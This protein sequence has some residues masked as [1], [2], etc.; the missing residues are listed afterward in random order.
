MKRLLLIFN[1][2]FLITYFSFAKNFKLSPD[3]GI[4]VDSAT[5]RNVRLVNDTMFLYYGQD[6]DTNGTAFGLAIATDAPN[7]VNF[8]K[9]N[10]NDY[11]AYNWHILPDGT[12]RKYFYDNAQSGVVS[13]SSTNGIISSLD[14]GVRYG[15]HSSDNNT[16]GVSTYFNDSLD[17]VH[18]LYIGDMGGMDNVRHAISTD[19]GW[20]F[21]YLT[22]NTFGDILGP[23]GNESYWDPHA[24]VMPDHSV[25]VFVINQHGI[26]AP[27]FNPTGLLYS[28]LSTDNGQTFS[29]ET[30]VNGDSIRLKFDDFTSFTNTSLNDPKGVLLPD[31]R[32]KVYVNGLVQ[33]P[34]N[35]YTW[36]IISA[37][38]DGPLSVEKPLNSNFQ[39]NVFPNPSQGEVSINLGQEFEQIETFIFDLSGQMVSSQNF[40]HTQNFNLDLN[41]NAGVYFLK[42]VSNNQSETVK[43]IVN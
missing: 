4:R 38:S 25:R 21:S 7:Y 41:L 2:G 5:T 3:I 37:T 16:Y 30:D 10:I 34:D 26:G 31:G 28:F 33:Q 18:I 6:L 32:I 39:M 17:N 36:N 12:F 19:A 43:L 15:L 13:E 20:T 27:P 8:T 9:V 35:S 40:S 1:F 42:V 22:N 11:P 24:V 29:L 23:G 14:P